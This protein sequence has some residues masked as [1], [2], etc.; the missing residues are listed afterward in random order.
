MGWFIVNIAVPVFVPV[1]FLGLAKLCCLPSSAMKRTRLVS[2]FE[3]G[4][5]GWVAL[6]FTASAAFEIYLYLISPECTDPFRAGVLL[7]IDL[8]LLVSAGYV[9]AT[10]ALFPVKT[11]KMPTYASKH[12]IRENRLM[13]GTSILTILAASTY[14]YVHL[15]LTHH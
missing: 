14:V 10:G 1:L 3:N 8:T 12:W 4:Q 15:A 11:H 6:G 13:L 7:G 9:A 5:L 2:L